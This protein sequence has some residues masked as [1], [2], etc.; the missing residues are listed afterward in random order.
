MNKYVDT[1]N[2]FMEFFNPQTGDYV[3]TGVMVMKDGKGLIDSGIDPFTRNF[4]ALIDIGVMGRCIHGESGL[5]VKSG[6]ECYQDGLNI[7]KENMSVEDF[8]SILK[9]CKGKVFQCIRDTEVVLLKKDIDSTPK[10]KYIKDAEVGNYVYNGVDFCKISEV[11]KKTVDSFL[12]I[13]TNG[14]RV[15]DCTE[16]HKFP[17]NDI[18]NIIQAEDIR[19]GDKVFY[20]DFKLNKEDKILN[21]IDLVKIIIDKGL[22]ST[23]FI[24]NLT[25]ICK[26]N[27]IKLTKNGTVRLDKVKHLISYDDYKNSEINVERSQYKLKS[28]LPINDELLILLGH[29]IG[30]GSHRTYTMDKSKTI[31]CEKIENAL[32]LNFKEFNYSKKIEKNLI[33]LELN[34][35]ILHKKVFDILLECRDYKKEKQLP[36]FLINCSFNQKVKFLRGYFCDGCIDVKEKDGTYASL[37]FNTSSEKLYK[38]LTIL[39]HSMNIKF[40]I[41]SKSKETSFYKKE[42]RYMNKK[43]R[44]RVYISNKID[45]ERLL[46]VVQDHKDFEKFKECSKIKNIKHTTA[47][48]NDKDII[49]SIE[50]IDK[51][52]EVV[53][54]NIESEDRLF[55]TTNGILTH[56]CALG[57]RGDVNKHENFEEILKVCKENDVV[58]NFTTSGLALTQE[59]VD[60]TKKYIGAVAISEY[61]NEYTREAI[62]KFVDAG[63]ITNIHYVLG[64]NTIDEAIDKLRNDG[65]DKGIN[66]VLFLLH[67]PVG[68]GSS[69]NV[70][71]PDCEKV[72]EFFEIIDT[73]KFDFKIGFDSC[74]CAGIVNNTKNI[75]DQ[76]MD[77]CEGS[78]MSCYIDA[79][80]N[81]MPCSFG[82]DN[83]KYHISLKEVSVKEAWDSE[84]FEKFRNSLR[85]SCKSCKD[86][87]NC[88]GGCPIVNEI[89]LCNRKERDFYED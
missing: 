70:L 50:S 66:A 62:K 3:R 30:N 35:R 22:D 28:V 23:F 77:Y 13:K 52:I 80:S 21:E 64:N 49:K 16:D 85:Y 71:Q 82:N 61:R 78:R 12:R 26:S 8:S 81:M 15:I 41:Y 17:I 20:S 53:D 31:M 72:K 36:S 84:I 33:K 54:I 6:I 60:I 55:M 32:S 89:T 51:K 7:K 19:L 24:S 27:N 39:L 86:R 43:R 88:R 87:D 25:S 34:S 14:G 76:S 74:S 1:D 44:F 56:N 63:V 83:P 59:E 29:Y 75:N 4:P 73:Q 57:G 46:E 37:I 9:Q 79:Q 2:K 18:K 5:C 65:F 48:M 69:N 38:D 45:I 40:N 67:K 42:N 68:L 10:L 58:P 47:Q 11:N